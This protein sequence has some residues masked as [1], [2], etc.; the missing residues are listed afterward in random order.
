[1]RSRAARTE[2][3]VGED[4][5]RLSIDAV[6]ALLDEVEQ[7]LARLD[8]GSY[9]RCEQ[10][11]EPIGDERLIEL[12]IARTCAACAGIGRGRLTSAQRRP[13]SSG[14]VTRPA[15]ESCRRQPWATLTRCQGATA[16]C[17]SQYSLSRPW[18]FTVQMNQPTIGRNIQNPVSP[19][20]GSS[21]L[22]ANRCPTL[23][24]HQEHIDD[25][26]EEGKEQTQ[27]AAD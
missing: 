16:P 13:R 21:L 20:T 11:G 3:T 8:D 27:S 23:R 10:C 19:V 2:A 17:A 15:L 5:Q 9:G 6:D 1:M 26:D 14:P 4:A 24:R 25:A 7:A 22:S 12:A 18:V